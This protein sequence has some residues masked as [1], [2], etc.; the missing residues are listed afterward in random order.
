MLMMVIMQKVFFASCNVTWVLDDELF[1]VHF[2]GEISH[3]Q[4]ILKNHWPVTF[5]VLVLVNEEDQQN[6][7]CIWPF[8]D[9]HKIFVSQMRKTRFDFCIQS[10]WA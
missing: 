2:L 6:D 4:V 8:H 10:E 7:D 3:V 9:F 5:A 1:F